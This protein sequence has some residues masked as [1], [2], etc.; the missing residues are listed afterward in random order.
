[1][2]VLSHSTLIDYYNKDIKAKAALEHWYQTVKRAEWT[3]FA[4]IKKDFNTVDSVGNQRYV[5]DIKGND[6]RLVVIVRFS[7]KTIFIRFVG[8]HK[9]YDN[10][11]DIKSI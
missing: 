5:F 9:E 10:I 6:Y 11:K 1:M 4:D 2:R 7:I 8:T 3:C